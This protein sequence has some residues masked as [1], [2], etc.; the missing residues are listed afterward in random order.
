MRLKVVV[1]FVGIAACALLLRFLPSH[2]SPVFRAAEDRPDA[3]AVEQPERTVAVSTPPAAIPVEVVAEQTRARA[4][5]PSHWAVIAATYN[6]FA[7]A[8]RRASALRSQYADCSCGV[9]PRDGE[10]QRYYVVVASGVEQRAA[11]EHRERAVAAGFPEDT[12][13]TKL[14]ASSSSGE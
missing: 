7:S 3:L 11:Q 9:Y 4:G 1:F 2:A 10:G 12:Y 6:S 13:V 5:G 14:V 8:A